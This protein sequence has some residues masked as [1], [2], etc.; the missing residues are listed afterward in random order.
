MQLHCRSTEPWLKTRKRPKNG[1]E[2]RQSPQDR[3]KL[4]GLYECILCACCT[5]ACPAYWWNP[6]EYL[7]PAA[8]INAY[9]WVSDSREDYTVERLE[10][11]LADDKKL[12][13][14]RSIKNCTAACPKSFDPASAI[15]IM[16]ARHKLSVR[17]EKN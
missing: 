17:L 1:R 16:R 5:T 10:A 12:D 9:R 6:E 4:D 15:N 8:L 14:C 2:Y 7:G 13:R 11:L 3:K